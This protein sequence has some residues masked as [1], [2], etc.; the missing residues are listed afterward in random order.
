MEDLQLPRR[1]EVDVILAE[2][3][4][5][6]NGTIKVGL[7]TLTLLVW[8][9]WNQTSALTCAWEIHSKSLFCCFLLALSCAPAFMRTSFCVLETVYVSSVEGKSVS[10]SSST[11]RRKRIHAVQISHLI[12]TRSS[13]RKESVCASDWIL[14]SCQPH[15]VTSGVSDESHHVLRGDI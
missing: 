15:K 8:D 10:L 7:G 3:S 2:C 6:W 12:L 11:T 5:H 14:M 13:G 1:V 9:L 4:R